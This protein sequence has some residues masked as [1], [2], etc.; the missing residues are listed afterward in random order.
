[1]SAVRTP[2]VRG[3]KVGSVAT[4]G[5]STQQKGL[6]LLAAALVGPSLLK[7]L[8][9]SPPS[10]VDLS[11]YKIVSHYDTPAIERRDGIVRVEFCA[12]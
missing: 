7:R 3:G 1:M 10:K 5:F 12:S 2:Y 9:D 4:G 11:A 8:Y 6:F